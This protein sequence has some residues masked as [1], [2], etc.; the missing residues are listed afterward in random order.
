MFDYKPK[1]PTLFEFGPLLF[2]PYLPATPMNLTVLYYAGNCAVQ[3]RGCAGATNLQ[4]V[5][6]CNPFCLVFEI[7]G[8]NQFS[9]V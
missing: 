6:K 9:P 2:K 5:S 1:P 7:P 4:H 3:S 8:N